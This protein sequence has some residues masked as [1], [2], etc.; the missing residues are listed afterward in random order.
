MLIRVM[1]EELEDGTQVHQ[2]PCPTFLHLKLYFAQCRKSEDNGSLFFLH[3]VAN[4]HKL[5][6]I[7][8]IIA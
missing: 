8:Q 2:S 5:H 4:L 6:E 3:F 7:R 1:N